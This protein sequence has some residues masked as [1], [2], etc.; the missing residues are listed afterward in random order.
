MQHHYKILGI[1]IKGSDLYISL[2]LIG[3][4]LVCQH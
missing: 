3:Y 4:Y 2:V 1:P